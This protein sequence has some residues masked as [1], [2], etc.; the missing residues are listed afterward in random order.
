METTYKEFG[1]WL[2]EDVDAETKQKY[3]KANKKLHQLMLFENELV[4]VD[5]CLCINS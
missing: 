5:V 2:G 1:E 4:C 3:E